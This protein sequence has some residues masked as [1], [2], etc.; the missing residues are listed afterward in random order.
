MF[1]RSLLTVTTH[2]DFDPELEK[3]E[4]AGWAWQAIERGWSQ[5]IVC[6][7]PCCHG[8]VVLVL[9]LVVVYERFFS[10]VRGETYTMT[11][12]GP[13]AAESVCSRS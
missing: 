10:R 2:A 5:H 11:A 1:T 7:T 9:T 6:T 13:T 8:R 4:L 3:M 12:R